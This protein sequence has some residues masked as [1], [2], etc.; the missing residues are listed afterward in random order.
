M[1][2][3]SRYEN[4]NKKL[5]IIILF[6]T[7]GPLSNLLLAT[8]G[9]RDWGGG[10]GANFRIGVM[11]AICLAVYPFDPNQLVPLLI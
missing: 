9:G 4:N 7:V 5:N 3:I 11:R 1:N 2:I 8:F 6:F 10:K